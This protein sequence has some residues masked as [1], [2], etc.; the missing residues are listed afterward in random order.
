MTVVQSS[1]FGEDALKSLMTAFD[2]LGKMNGDL[3]EIWPIIET[4]VPK[5]IR[6]FWEAFGGDATPYRLCAPDIERLISRDIAYTRL[7]FV[8]GV[9][10]ALIDKMERRGRASSKDRV[11]EI[12]FAAGLLRSYQSRHEQL[13]SSLGNDPKRLKRLTHS[14]Y[15]LYA[16]ENSVLFN[17]AALARADE[18]RAADT[19]NRSRLAAIDRSAC[20]LEISMDG[21]VQDANENFLSIMGYSKEQIVG[22]Y[23]KSF[24]EPDF[25][26]SQ[27]YGQFW[28]RLRQGQFVQGEFTRLSRSGARVYLQATYSPILDEEGNPVRIVKYATDVTAVRKAERDEADNAER[29][30]QQATTR[31]SAHEGTL[32]KLARIVEEIRAI[33][34]Q[35][36]MLALNASIEAARVGEA[37]KAFEVVA[38]EVKAL[39]AAT[40][41]ATKL[42]ISV[43]DDGREAVDDS[44]RL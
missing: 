26:S 14:L 22:M 38:R 37:G 28:N 3:A 31:L 29:F 9:N 7:K 5:E 32:I 10:Q 18:D 33:S 39:A 35:T 40:N 36:S 21:K 30:R 34:S 41:S 20:W 12:S 25:V 19:E 42:A 6:A 23:H 16:L 8:G 24:C 44:G 1:R 13:T 11:T 2:P 17:G 15:S 27:A 4:G 43:L